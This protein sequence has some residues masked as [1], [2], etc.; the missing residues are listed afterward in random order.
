MKARTNLQRR[1]AVVVG[2][3]LTAL[4]AACNSSGDVDTSQQGSDTAVN[5]A[6]DAVAKAAEPPVFEA[7]P[8]FDPS[9]A[10]GKKLWIID[11]ASSIPMIQ[12]G[13]SATADALGLVGATVETH[14][15]KGSVSEFA[16]GVNQAIADKADAI[17]LYAVD[18]RAVEGPLRKAHDAGIKIIAIQ[19]DDPGAALPDYVDAQVTYCYSCAGETMANYIVSAEGGKSVGVELVTS[20]EVSNSAPLIK[21]FEATLKKGCP[22]CGLVKDDVP[23]ASWQ[24]DIPTQVNSTLNSH[25]DIKYVVP[26]YDGMALFAAP[27][28]QTSGRDDVKLVTFNATESVMQALQD[29]KIV[30][31][32]VGSPQ[33]W[34]G[35]ALAD[36]FLRLMSD[37]APLEDQGVDLRLFDES[38]VGD[39]DLSAPESEW[40]QVDFESVYK[41]AWGIN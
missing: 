22:G 35:W 36:Q 8:S 1:G 19:F 3:A 2:I 33:A 4:L 6:E 21:A 32:D 30:A 14:D 27:A 28:I 5:E 24:T 41:S 37:E 20:T 15:G 7:P 23:V 25:P 34:Q 18:P 16:L 11:L 9:A 26:I 38:N 17:A 39:I 10:K 13:D 40:Y 31:A 29:K 12:T